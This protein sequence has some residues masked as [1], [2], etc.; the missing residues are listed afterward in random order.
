LES[1]GSPLR[2]EQKQQASKQMTRIRLKHV[3]AFRNLNRNEWDEL[4]RDP[5][6]TEERAS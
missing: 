4:L 6:I 3:N 2:S 5:V 1:F